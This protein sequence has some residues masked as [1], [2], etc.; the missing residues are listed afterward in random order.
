QTGALASYGEQY[1]EGF[2]A[3]LAYATNG[4]NKVGNHPIEVTILDDAGDPAKGVAAANELIGEGYQIL[5]GSAVSGIA[6]Q[7]APV[8]EQNKVLFVSGPAATDGL[9]ALNRYTFRS[10]RQS[11]QDVM[12]A[13]SFIGTP[14]GKKVVVF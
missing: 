7:L 14:A 9:T 13:S 4:T 12:T 6:L 2:E 3:G 8:A 1:L 10:G 11:F 5:A